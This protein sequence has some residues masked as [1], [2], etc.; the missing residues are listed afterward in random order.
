[1]I[2]NKLEKTYIN[3]LEERIKEFVT[4]EAN[5][6]I[7]DKVAEFR[8]TL[9]SRKGEYVDEIMKDIKVYHESSS[10]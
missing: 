8:R 7:D 5:K 10:V 3:M 4:L 6:I 9:E 2:E 1:M